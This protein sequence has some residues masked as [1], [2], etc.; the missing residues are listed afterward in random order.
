[1]LQNLVVL[2]STYF[3]A[4]DLHWLDTSPGSVGL[5]YNI[6]R[7]FDYPTNWTLLNTTPHP[8][9]FYRDQTTL[10]SVTYTVTPSDWISL[11]NDGQWCFKIPSAP[12]WSPQLV[13][14]APIVAN[15]P[16]DVVVKVDGNSVGVGRLDGQEGLVYLEAWN[17]AAGGAKQVKKGN[18]FT[19]NQVPTQVVTVTYNKLLN[20]VNI[21]LAGGTVR[22]FYTVVPVD[23][24]GNEAYAPGTPGTEIKST[25]EVDQMDYMFAEMIR[26]NAWLF[27]QVGEP[28]FLMIRKH[29]GTRCECTIANGEPRS[30]CSACYETGI[31][32]GYYGPYDVLF[33]DPD[34]QA[35]R[36]L[37][38][39]GVRVERESQSYLGP[40]PYVTD[41]DLIIRR[42]GERLSIYGVTYKQPRGILVQQNFNVSLLQ[43]GDTRY[44]IPVTTTPTGSPTLYDPRFDT[45]DLPSEPLT[46]P[47]VDPTKTWENPVVPQGRTVK[48][49]NIM[50]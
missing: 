30:G 1:M 43:P 41:G 32:G 48:F 11:G 5:G 24:Q 4:R 25:L 20:Y 38:E 22:T 29:R 37:N 12:I 17:L 45:Q 8:G 50:S 18:S 19:S 3:G 26:R 7:A 14:G 46:N 16:L 28:A 23:A 34:S 39:G 49:G 47:L 36:I 40:T 2:D 44:M 10:Q 42:N 21:Y 13:K 15:N 6:Y 33:I 9:L 31:V 35:T 27:E